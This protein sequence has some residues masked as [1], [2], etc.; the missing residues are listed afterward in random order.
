MS[1]E[2]FQ[3]P[4]MLGG[5]LVKRFSLMIK[6]DKVCKDPDVETQDILII[7]VSLL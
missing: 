1:S 2:E 3:N 7:V 6:L 4:F 5:I